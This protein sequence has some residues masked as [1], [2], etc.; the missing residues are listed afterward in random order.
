MHISKTPSM[1]STAA[2][3]LLRTTKTLPRAC[4]M[5]K[6]L[7]KGLSKRGDQEPDAHSGWGTEIV[8]GDGFNFSK[9][10]CNTS[11][12]EAS[13]QRK[14]QENLLAESTLRTLGN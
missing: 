12:Q 4:H 8:C 13:P 10:N 11:S 7:E 2:W 9:E 14:T 1:A 3:T 5:V 6:L